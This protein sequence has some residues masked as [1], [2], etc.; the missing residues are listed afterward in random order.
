[1]CDLDNWFQSDGLW[2]VF[3]NRLGNF[4]QK[5]RC[6]IFE[7]FACGNDIHNTLLALH[8]FQAKKQ[9]A[10]EQPGPLPSQAK[11][12]GAWINK[13]SKPDSQWPWHGQKASG[14]VTDPTPSGPKKPPMAIGECPCLLKNTENQALAAD[15]GRNSRD[16]QKSAVTM[17]ARIEK[18]RG[19]MS[20]SLGPLQE[21]IL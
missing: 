8:K 1:M 17:R 15:Q 3:T 19:T 16:K 4:F 10:A 18:P 14:A 21:L 6:S 11:S 5:Q 7:T 9:E 20:A 13:Q 2:N 12:D